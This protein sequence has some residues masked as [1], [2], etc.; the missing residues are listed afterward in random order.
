MFFYFFNTQDH[1]EILAKTIAMKYLVCQNVCDKLQL[2]SVM[3]QCK[4]GS[5][6]ATVSMAI[7]ST[8][9]DHG[10]TEI[11][12]SLADRVFSGAVHYTPPTDPTGVNTSVVGLTPSTVI[13]PT[14]VTSIVII[15]AVVAAFIVAVVIIKW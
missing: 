1:S 6:L 3:V 8:H 10:V 2:A 12:F 11:S 7:P 4:D 9:I 14:V 13:V 5:E 15:V